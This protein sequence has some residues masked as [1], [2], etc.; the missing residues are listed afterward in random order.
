MISD[1]YAV[2]CIKKKKR[3]H[4]EY[5][6]RYL[7]NY[8]LYNVENFVNLF[9]LHLA[10]VN[11]FEIDD[12]NILWQH[13]H[14]IALDILEIMCPYRRYKQRAFPSPWLTPEI[15][16]EIRIRTRL[17]KMFNCSRTNLLLTM[18]RR[19]RNKVNGLIESA[20]RSYILNSLRRNTK[21][22]R[23]FWRIIND[24]LKGTSNMSQSVQF[25]DPDTDTP[26][27]DG[28]QSD[29]LNSYFCN[30]SQRLGLSSDP[31]IDPESVNGLH[32]FYG[33]I[34]SLFDLSEDEILGPEL[35]DIVKT[36]DISK[37]S[38]V[39][40]I[41]TL[42]C[43]HIMTHFSNEISYLF[44]R[45]ITSGIF[46]T[47]WSKG[48]ITVIPKSGRL[49]D[50]S[51]WRPITQ[52][53]I[54]AKTLEKLVHHRMISYFDENLILS[55]YQ[56]GFRTQ[57]STQQSIFDF[58]KF[59]YSSLNNKKLFC[60]ICLDV[61]KAF[62][63]INHDVLLFKL[64]KIG[65]S[66]SSLAWFKSYLTRTQVVKFNDVTSGILPI[67][68]GIGQRT[69]L[70]PLLFIFYINDIIIAKGNLMI[71]IYAD[72]C[73]LF[74]SGNNWDSMIDLIQ[75]DLDNI[76]LWCKRNRLKLSQNKSKV[77]L[78]GS[79]NKLRNVDY[80][81]MVNLDNV[82]LNFVECY[83]YLGITIDKTMD[84]TKQLSLVKK[85]VMNHLFKLRKICK[86]IN[87]EC[88]VIIYKQTILPVLDYSG[89]LL[90]S[91]N[92]S[93]R[94]DLQILQNDALR[95]CYNVNCPLDR[96]T[97]ILTYLA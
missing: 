64:S 78:I 70:G 94:H 50:L 15:Y 32:D 41:S 44:R 95:T 83:K 63:C 59:V 14:S 45:S 58:L 40:G 19:Q 30:I 10:R 57:R 9:R 55:P 8:T 88:A 48:C 92:V 85:T 13:I 53:S 33:E 71:N 38:C 39:E 12:P 25:Q 5:V 54:F 21:N 93:D 29:F 35:E 3:E 80:A 73:I 37:S 91:C 72:D 82:P 79:L 62:D 56:Y 65:F 75:P 61:C 51:N 84:L 52:T 28:S 11:F 42:I 68:T 4:V 18:M 96:C 74:K 2:H 89:F 24:M 16:R 90:H 20:K 31:E 43:K 22:P 36:I 1:H 86:Y 46:P 67:I 49:S 87:Q 26:V 60:A 81:T 17:V 23:K 7:R 76:V 6:Y 77:L 27:P 34:D 97:I 66:Q 69:I 47:E